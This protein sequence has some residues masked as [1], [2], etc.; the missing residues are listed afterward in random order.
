MVKSWRDNEG[1]GVVIYVL[2]EA[3]LYG[4]CTALLEK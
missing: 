4:E 3:T 1:E 2:V